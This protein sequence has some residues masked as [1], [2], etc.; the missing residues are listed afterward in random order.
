MIDA[1]RI[2][3]NVD[4]AL[5]R[6]GIF[7]TQRTSFSGPSPMEIGNVEQKREDLRNNACFKCH[8]LGCRPNRCGAEYSRPKNARGNKKSNSLR[9]SNARINLNQGRR[10]IDSEKRRSADSKEKHSGWT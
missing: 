10:N 1:S 5:W 6:A 7:N 9:V 3:L 2:A 8:T 4:S